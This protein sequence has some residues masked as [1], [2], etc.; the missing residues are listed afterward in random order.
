M[1]NFL[2]CRFDCEYCCWW[3][4]K[5]WGGGTGGGIGFDLVAT[6]FVATGRLVVLVILGCSIDALECAN[7]DTGEPDFC[8]TMYDDAGEEIG[9]AGM[10]KEGVI[11][12]WGFLNEAIVLRSGSLFTGSAIVLGTSSTSL[13]VIKWLLVSTPGG[14]WANWGASRVAVEVSGGWSML[15]RGVSVTWTPFTPPG[16]IWLIK[17]AKSWS[18]C[19]Q[20]EFLNSSLATLKRAIKCADMAIVCDDLSKGT[21]R[22]RQQRWMGEE[23]RQVF[24]EQVAD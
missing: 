14:I 5:G 2:L 1:D 15:S 22:R 6:V 7:A 17:V 16:C 3:D 12:C 24:Q 23:G 19:L 8:E 11:V 4:T 10:T 13:G 20:T 21:G 9:I 18:T